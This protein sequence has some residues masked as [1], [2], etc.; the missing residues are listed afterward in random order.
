MAFVAL[1]HSAFAHGRDEEAERVTK[2]MRDAL[3]KLRRIEAAS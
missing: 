1:I 2:Q 3:D